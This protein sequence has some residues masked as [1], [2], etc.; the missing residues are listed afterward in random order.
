MWNSENIVNIYTEIK[1]VSIMETLS[2]KELKAYLEAEKQQIIEEYGEFDDRT[3][4][5]FVRNGGA[6]RFHDKY[7]GKQNLVNCS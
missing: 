6:E 7:F 1:C 3:I 5:R 4:V 2:K